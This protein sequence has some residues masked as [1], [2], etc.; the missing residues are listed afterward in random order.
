M[1]NCG[2]CVVDFVDSTG[3]RVEVDFVARRIDKIDR[4]GVTHSSQ[5]T[6]IYAE[7]LLAM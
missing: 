5:V 6:E 3:D 7:K 2:H 4:I 1:S